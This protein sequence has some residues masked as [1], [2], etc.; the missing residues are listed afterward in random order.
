MLWL[1][2]SLSRAWKVVKKSHL[3]TKREITLLTPFFYPY[4]I[5]TFSPPPLLFSLFSMPAQSFPLLPSFTNSFN[6]NN[7]EQVQ[8]QN[9]ISLNILHLARFIYYLSIKKEQKGTQIRFLLLWGVY[10]F[11]INTMIFHAYLTTS[12][13]I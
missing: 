11:N 13:F 2:Q 10:K 9:S 1:S 8:E 7:N 4:F 3:F 12:F 5:L 6:L